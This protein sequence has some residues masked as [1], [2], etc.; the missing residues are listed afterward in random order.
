MQPSSTGDVL[1]VSALNKQA[2]LT[3][4]DRF[5][6]VWVTGELSNFARPASGHWYFT[7]KDANAQV[8]CAMFVNS[9]RRVQMQPS[10]GQQVLLR[11]RVSLYEGRGEFQIIVEHMAPAGEGALRQAFE[12]LKRKLDAE[13]LFDLARKRPLPKIPGHIAIITSPTG[14][15]LQDVVAVWQRRFSA[16]RVTLIPSSVQGEEAEGQILSALNRAE[17]LQPDMVLLTRGGGSLEDLWT[18]NLESIARRVSTLSVPVVSA[19]GHE[20]DTA[21]TDLVADA[22]APTPSAAAEMLVPD[23]E[24]LLRHF[25]TTH[26]QLERSMMALLQNRR[27]ETDKLALR[28]ISPE[29]RCQQAWQ[30]LDELGGRLGRQLGNQLERRTQRLQQARLNLWRQSPSRRLLRETDRKEA[31]VR[32]LKESIAR[33]IAES[34]QRLGNA[35]RILEGLSPLPTLARGYVLVRDAGGQLIDNVADMEPGMQ[36]TAQFRDGRTRVTVQ[37][38]QEGVFLSDA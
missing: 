35:A 20:I 36:V 27:L 28:L 7:L 4:E 3:I 29:Q 6:G 38:I 9:N 16:H 22:R 5:R 37:D 1:S 32:R 24:D 13:G 17:V 34:Q 26:K 10:N 25:G 30:R 15:A 23:R 18:F 21:I 19:I 33:R 2:R 8:R 11:G 12:A 14:A 31:Y